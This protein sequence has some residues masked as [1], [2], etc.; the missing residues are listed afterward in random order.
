MLNK[1]LPLLLLSLI[2]GCSSDSDTTDYEND[3]IES[4]S[5]S[6]NVTQ[7]VG[8]KIT[9]VA[10]LEKNLNLSISTLYIEANIPTGEKHAFSTV[11]FEFEYSEPSS[12]NKK[13]IQ[14]DQTLIG[15]QKVKA[16]FKNASNDCSA[17][18]CTFYQRVNFPISFKKLESSRKDGLVFLLKQTKNRS[19]ELGVM[20]PGRYITALLLEEN[21]TKQPTVT[22]KQHSNSM[23]PRDN[24]MNRSADKITLSSDQLFTQNSLVIK[25][26]RELTALTKKLLKTKN[27]ITISAHTDSIGE[28]KE[29]KILSVK[30]AAAVARYFISKG[31]LSSRLIVKGKGERKPIETNMYKAGRAKNRRVE[32]NY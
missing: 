12:K 21:E 7:L 31:V 17:G 9:P 28:Y 25:E 13:A 16:Q 22:K 27:P 1:L 29:N 30:R 14:F 18:S 20:I 2:T 11:Y 10:L 32:I 4:K 26:N 23:K 3:I 24:P 15:N 8:R 19:V 6:N 5:T